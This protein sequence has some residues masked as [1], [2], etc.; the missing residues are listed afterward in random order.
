MLLKEKYNA[1]V[2]TGKEKV[3]LQERTLIMWCGSGNHSSR[4]GKCH[5]SIFPVRKKWRMC[6]SGSTDA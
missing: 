1:L 5:Q 2:Y 3:E 4:C 6:G